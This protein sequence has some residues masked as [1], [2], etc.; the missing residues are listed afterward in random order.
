MS[1]EQM[2]VHLS[3]L[4]LEWMF[5][6]DHCALLIVKVAGACYRLDA[7]VEERA[8][9]GLVASELGVSPAVLRLVGPV[10]Q[11]AAI[12][13]RTSRLLRICTWRRVFY[14]LDVA[15]QRSRLRTADSDYI[16][17]PPRRAEAA[18]APRDVV[19]SEDTGGRT[20]VCAMTGPLGDD[21]CVVASEPLPTLCSATALPRGCE[22]GP[23]E[24]WSMDVAYRAVAYYEVSI[25]P[26]PSPLSSRIHGG[27]RAPCVSLGLCTSR[28]SRY[29]INN[30]QAGWDEESWAWH[31]DDGD[32]F[33]GNSGRGHNFSW[34]PVGELRRRGPARTRFRRGAPI[35]SRRVTFGE[36]DV[37]GCGVVHLLPSEADREE[38]RPAMETAGDAAS[39]SLA[40]DLREPWVLRSD[41]SRKCA[42][43][44]FFT[45]NGE[46][47]GVPFVID[48]S[49]QLEVPLFPC[50]GIDAHSDLS[51]NF[52]AKPFRFDLL[53]SLAPLEVRLADEW[54]TFEPAWLEAGGAPKAM[55]PLVSKFTMR[56][57]IGRWL[58]NRARTVARRY[59]NGLPL[60]ARNFGSSDSSSTSSSRSRRTGRRSR[61]IQRGLRRRF[62]QGGSSS[63][64]DTTS[65]SSGQ[66]DSD[67]EISHTLWEDAIDEMNPQMRAAIR[68]MR[69]QHS[70]FAERG[71]AMGAEDQRVGRRQAREGSDAEIASVSDLEVATVSDAAGSEGA[72][73]FS[74]MEAAIGLDDASSGDE[75]DYISGAST[76]GSRRL[77]RARRGQV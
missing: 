31:S 27:D 11:V 32:L 64:G 57:S 74:A 62:G 68:A 72:E 23:Q 22:R 73:V 75:S 33:H 2:A 36:G 26:C 3:Q 67:G 63:S 21:R 16:Y 58:S 77:A 34:A 7:E 10:P 28:L 46:F 12:G 53:G 40:H 13:A 39:Q 52:G 30:R 8:W 70:L 45:L 47:L 4:P 43:G 44:I 6:L 1:V 76:P 65:R 48:D 50:V 5:F 51:F 71:A 66:S 61:R 56:P 59:K 49:I 41:F 19:F 69:I 38:E 60:T 35:A 14:D 29:S 54:Q 18:E 9:R 42:R 25:A 37:V 24:A 15:C 20:T 17:F 55:R